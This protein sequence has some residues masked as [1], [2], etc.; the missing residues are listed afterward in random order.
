[1][2]SGVDAAMIA[3]QNAAILREVAWLRLTRAKQVPQ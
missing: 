2:R 3:G 1:M